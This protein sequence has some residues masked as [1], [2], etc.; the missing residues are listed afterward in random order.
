MFPK[1]HLTSHSRMSGSRWVIIP[2]WF[3]GSWRSFVQFFCV[4]LPPLLNIC[5][6]CSVR[7]ISVLFGV[8]LCMKCP[9]G[10]SNFLEEIFSL[11]HSIVFL[12]FFALITQEGFL[13]SP[14]CS[15]DLCIQ[16]II[17]FFPFC[18][19][20]LFF[21]QVFVRPSQTTILHFCIYFSWGW[22]WPLSPVQCHEPLSMVHQAL[23]QI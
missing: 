7:T 12:G 1:A 21:S 16:M 9:L 5:C 23:Y 14:C 17:S 4:F 13:I 11:S 3:S 8:H 19:S 6:F 18:F 2:S 10:I 20:L 22:S 15:L